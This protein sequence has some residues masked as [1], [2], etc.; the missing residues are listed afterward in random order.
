MPGIPII[1]ATKPAAAVAAPIFASVAQAP[2]P[3]LW[4]LAAAAVPVV[5]PAM[6]IKT[7]AEKAEA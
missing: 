3:E 2:T 1:M 6:A 5:K 4:L 7:A